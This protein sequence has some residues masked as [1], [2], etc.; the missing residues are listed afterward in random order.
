ME[1]KATPVPIVALLD[2]EPLAAADAL[3]AGVVLPHAR[4]IKLVRRPRASLEIF[5]PLRFEIR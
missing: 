4:V 3:A 2:Q 5:G 1:A